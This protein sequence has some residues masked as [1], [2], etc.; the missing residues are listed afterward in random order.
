VELKASTLIVSPAP[1]TPDTADL[2][3]SVAILIF[4]PA[5]LPLVSSTMMASTGKRWVVARGLEITP[6]LT[7]S[8]IAVRVDTV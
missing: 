7:V 5:M 8:C 1:S 6:M 3:E 4:E 2:I